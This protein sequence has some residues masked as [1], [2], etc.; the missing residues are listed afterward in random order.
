VYFDGRELTY[1]ALLERTERVAGSLRARGLGPG[2]RVAVLLRNIPEFLELN[3]AIPGSGLVLVPLNTRL[4][5]EDYRHILEHAGAKALVTSDDFRD[6]VEAAA[7]SLDVI[8]VGSEYEDLVATGDRLALGE[9]DEQSLFSINYTSG[10][11]GKPKGAMYCHR[12]SYLHA[13]GVIAEAKLDV[14]SSYL[15]VLP[16]FH[17]HGW[18]F[19]WAVT[20]A[21]A[22]H[23][24]VDGFDA[25]EAWRLLREQRITHL[26]GAP[27]VI[28]MLVEAVEASSLADPVCVFVG[29]APPTPSLFERARDLGL[30]LLHLYGMTETYGPIVACTWRPEWDEQPPARQAELR[31]RQGVATLVST[32]VRVVDEQMVDVPAD[33]ETPG[34]I[35]MQG[36][37]VMLGYYADTETTAEAFRGGWFHSGDVAVMHRDGY[38]QIRD[39]VKDIIVTGG[40]NV[41]TVEVEAALAAHPSVAEAAVIGVPDP[42]WGE[43]VKAYVVRRDPA[44]TDEEL[45]AFAREKLAGFKVPKTIEF[46][47][48]LPKTATGKIQ[49]FVL[50]QRNSVLEEAR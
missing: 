28:T 7:P 1:A 30:H 39:R 12:G 8:Y 24:C 13:L 17:C 47:D 48:D 49:K 26:C 25:A 35:V 43:A 23:V 27:T 31:S 11:T 2:D 18:A 20:A 40:E 21:G 4:T 42:R 5:A 3:F 6:V 10:T 44:L 19:P 32:P 45:Q 38:I 46:L 22:R 36:N 15:W 33:G 34:E 14:S 9:V 29:G 37:N 41:S 50:R 16:M